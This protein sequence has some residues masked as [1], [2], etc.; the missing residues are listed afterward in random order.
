[1]IGFSFVVRNKGLGD[2]VGVNVL[3][4]CGLFPQGCEADFRWGLF[5]GLFKRSA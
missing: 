3:I 1:M 4:G 5:P 2:K